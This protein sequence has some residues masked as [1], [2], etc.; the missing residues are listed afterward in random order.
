MSPRK[1]ALLGAAGAVVVVVAAGAA[2]ALTHNQGDVFNPKVGFQDEPTATP[3]PDTPAPTKKGAKDPLRNFVWATYG[4]TP[5]R[6]RYLDVSNRIR[7]P[8]K[9]RWY[10]NGHAL[11]EFSPSMALGKLFL[12]KDNGVA[13]ALNKATG[14]VVWQRKVGTLAAA[15]PAYSGGRIFMP[16][17]NRATGKLGSV[18]ALRA[19]DG[20]V[21]WTHPIPSR[22]ESS[23]VVS[24]GRVYLGSEDG[25]VYAL[26]VRD[27]HVV[28][29]FHASGA[30]KG[31]PALS[32][33]RLYFG[34]YSGRVYAVRA[35]NGS[36]VWSTGTSG[37]LFGLRSGQ[38]YSSPA[39][40]FGR[41]YIGNTDGRMYSFSADRGK[42]AWTKGTGSYVYASPAAVHL[43]GDKPTV[44]FGSYDGTF[45]ACDARTG[46]VR[47]QYRDGGKISG[48]PTI[49]G[50]IVYYSNLG[51]HDTTGLN[52]RNGHK[53]FHWGAGAFNP[54]ISDGRDIFL[55]GNSSVTSLRPRRYDGPAGPPARA[56]PS[57]HRSGKSHSGR[58][59]RKAQRQHRRKS[60]R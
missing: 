3:V 53:V 4:Y 52:A 22:S 10:W 18:I 17:L 9:R 34:D 7:P 39:V 11:L 47:W 40:A 24:G 36:Q 35:S 44:Y 15:T 42:L 32:N 2:W 50:G 43:P 13:V 49:I 58:S 29:R 31:G 38:F 12:L 54:V 5:D 59:K 23:A 57:R 8:F 56:R 19:R 1:K 41:V 55:T 48:S 6:R 21:E 46:A 14:R 26:G 51:H 20:K 16:V 27:G 33:G 60:H 25:T 45:Y 37:S 30:V 28:W